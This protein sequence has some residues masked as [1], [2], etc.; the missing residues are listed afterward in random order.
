MTMNNDLPY[1]DLQ[2]IYL[3]TGVILKPVQGQNFE[4][5]L[6]PCVFSQSVMLEVWN[7]DDEPVE[8]M[9]PAQ[10]AERAIAHVAEIA[11]E[12]A[13]PLACR[14]ALDHVVVSRVLESAETTDTACLI[15]FTHS[16]TITVGGMRG[17]GFRK[18]SAKELERNME[19]AA[20]PGGCL[21]MQAVVEGEVH[22]MHHKGTVPAASLE[23]YADFEDILDDVEDLIE[24]VVDVHHNDDF[25][26]H[27]ATLSVLSRDP[28]TGCSLRSVYAS[29]LMS[30]EDQPRAH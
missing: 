14:A 7:E 13:M 4:L 25:S 17:L 11:R 26:L 6:T 2:Q 12:Y 1:P 5:T 30:A 29:C 24:A 27:T 9:P 18:L 15:D 21:R 16:A 10:D 23:N 22:E 20:S 19:Q 3:Y 8:W 28:E